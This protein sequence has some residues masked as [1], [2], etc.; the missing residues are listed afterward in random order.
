MSVLVAKR[1]STQV[2]GFATGV[3][4]KADIGAPPLIQLSFMSARPNGAQVLFLTDGAVSQRLDDYELCA[5]L[6]DGNDEAA[7]TAA[8][9]Q[10]RGLKD[11]N[12]DLTYWQQDAQGRWE[13]KD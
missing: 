8:R 2:R 10:W 7:P 1:G 3:G 6:F 12:H 4:A 5:V 13:K 9:E 11:S